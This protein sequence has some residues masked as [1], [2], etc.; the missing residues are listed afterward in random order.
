M[1]NTDF[2]LDKFTDNFS[3]YGQVNPFVVFDL[4]VLKRASKSYTEHN[5]LML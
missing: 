2:F 5:E 4:C 1:R 3:G